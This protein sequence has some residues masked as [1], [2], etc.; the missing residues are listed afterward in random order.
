[1]KNVLE[2]DMEKPIF[3]TKTP[4]ATKLRLNENETLA[5]TKIIIMTIISTK[6]HGWRNIQ[7]SANAINRLPILLRIKGHS[8]KSNNRMAQ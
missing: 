7:T 3:I 8:P 2:G 5:K 1:M 4:I 6:L